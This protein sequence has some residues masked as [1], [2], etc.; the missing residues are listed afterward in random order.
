ME[1]L[2]R[3]DGKRNSFRYNVTIML[4]KKVIVRDG[5]ALQLTVTVTVSNHNAQQN[6]LHY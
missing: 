6:A 3:R 4:G 5:K 1:L 2:D